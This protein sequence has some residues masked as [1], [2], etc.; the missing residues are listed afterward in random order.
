[1]LPENNTG[2]DDETVERTHNTK[3]AKQREEPGDQ[4]RTSTAT[5][6]NIATDKLD[7]TTG[8]IR[9]KQQ[10]RNLA[11]STEP[12]LM[13]SSISKFNRGEHSMSTKKKEHCDIKQADKDKES[14]EI[15]RHPSNYV[16]NITW[17]NRHTTNP[18]PR[19]GPR[20]GGN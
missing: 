3:M 7:P 14:Q 6:D 4:K 9:E 1:M 17:T 8:S 16:V 19:T 10:D 11:V 13:K 2:K 5:L 18:T 20:S 15:P 12:I